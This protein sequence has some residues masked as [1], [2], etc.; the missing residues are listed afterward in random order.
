M[1]DP[2]DIAKTALKDYKKRKP[3]SMFG[4]ISKLQVL[5]VRMMPATATMKVWM[6]QQ[7]LNKRG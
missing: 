5:A 7:K 2:T 6:G 1:Y 3:V 4:V